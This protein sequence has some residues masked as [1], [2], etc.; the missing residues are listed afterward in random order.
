MARTPTTA[1]GH[2]MTA[3]EIRAR[4]EWM[5]GADLDEGPDEDE[6]PRCHGDGMDP[7]NDYLLPC[8]LCQGE[9]YP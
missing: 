3:D 2:A 6:C 8:P 5:Y 7:W 9:Q 1:K 4:D